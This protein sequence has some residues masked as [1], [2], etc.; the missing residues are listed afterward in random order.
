MWVKVRARGFAHGRGG[1][2]LVVV[3]FVSRSPPQT[4]SEVAAI[5]RSVN[6][7]TPFGN[8]KW[9]ERTVKQMGLEVTT[10]PRGPPKLV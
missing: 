8:P 10:R 6:R 1:G 2:T 9:T 5:R 7:G 4:E 3:T